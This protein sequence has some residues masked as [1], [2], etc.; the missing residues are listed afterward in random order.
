LNK[1]SLSWI[2]A[3]NTTNFPDMEAFENYSSQFLSQAYDPTIDADELICSL[4]INTFSAVAFSSMVK[5]TNEN[6]GDGGTDYRTEDEEIPILS[7]I[8]HPFKESR[9]LSFGEKEKLF[10][11]H[12]N[13]SDPL[14]DFQVVEFV[15]PLDFFSFWK[16]K[17][18]KDAPESKEEEPKDDDDEEGVAKQGIIT[19]AFQDFFD[20]AQRSGEVGTVPVLE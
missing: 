5:K 20:D 19:S 12:T 17:N 1:A 6:T 11:I 7:V 15:N 4:C 16:T 14:K 2:E 13:K 10:G 9:A 8:L 18:K 3:Y